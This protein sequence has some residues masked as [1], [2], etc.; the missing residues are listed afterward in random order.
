MEGETRE[1]AAFFTWCKL[2][3]KLIDSKN[4]SSK[5]GRSK[6]LI[7]TGFLQRRRKGALSA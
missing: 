6:T 2:D 1:E 4:G 3:Q 7:A 5:T